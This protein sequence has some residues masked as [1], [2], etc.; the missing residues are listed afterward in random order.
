MFDRRYNLVCVN[1][2]IPSKDKVSIELILDTQSNRPWLDNAFAA[3]ITRLYTKYEKQVCLTVQDIE[4]ACEWM[5]EVVETRNNT[6]ISIEIKGTFNGK[7][8]NSTF[9]S[10]S[11]FLEFLKTQDLVESVAVSKLALGKAP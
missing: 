9:D 10:L 2:D 7:D 6:T 3:P 4:E 1:K 11:V 5:K 8:F